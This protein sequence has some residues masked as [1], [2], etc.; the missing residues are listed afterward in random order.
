MMPARGVSPMVLYLEILRKIER[1]E[2]LIVAAAINATA[3][4]MMTSYRR[5]MVPVETP[6]ER[7][8][9]GTTDDDF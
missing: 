2:R 7:I 6:L 8:P 1:N 5:K 4:E 9:D 3:G